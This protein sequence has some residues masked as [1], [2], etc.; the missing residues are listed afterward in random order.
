MWCVEKLQ[1]GVVV[2][3]QIILPMLVVVGVVAN[4]MSIMV[5]N[6]PRLKNIIG[7][8]YFLALSWCDLS[9]S[10]SC[11]IIAATACGCVFESYAS[12]WYYAHFG[13]S[14]TR[15]F[16]ALGNYII[17]F[18][19]LDRFVAVWFPVWFMTM[20][21]PLFDIT[22]RLVFATVLCFI[23]H[24]PYM[25][26]AAVVEKVNFCNNCTEAVNE[27]NCTSVTSVTYISID[28]F[29]KSFNQTWHEVFRYS[30]NQLFCWLPCAL[31]IVLN[32]GL[33]LAVVTKRVKVPRE[34]MLV[35]TAI[36]MTASYVV[37][38]MPI[39]IFLAG[40]AAANDNRCTESSPK[41]TLRHIG[42]ITQI[43]EH[44]LHGVYLLLINPSF[45]Q[46]LICL[47]QCRRSPTHPPLPT[48]AAL[49]AV[50]SAPS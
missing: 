5:L 10:I 33:V 36:V 20:T 22:N 24:V 49:S 2:T 16:H 32:F 12:A 7:N 48:V 27:D 6:R 25:V 29:Q 23:L 50:S 15:T 3:Y 41:E 9:Y 8:K 4:A 17:I 30:Y 28:G 38:T 37:M 39:T 14:I 40:Y 43:L 21:Q 42:N 13:W 18:M 34:K 46:E 31:L 45:R 19:S 26:D 35:A 44:V 1:D 47:L 11:I